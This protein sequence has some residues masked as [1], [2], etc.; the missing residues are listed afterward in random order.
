M[1]RSK[2]ITTFIIIFFLIIALII[3]G[4]YAMGFILRKNFLNGRRQV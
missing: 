2:K 3:I 4:R 1:K